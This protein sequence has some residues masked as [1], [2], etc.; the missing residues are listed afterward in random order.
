[1]AFVL[2]K[3][4]S[5]ASGQGIFCRGRRIIFS[6]AVHKSVTCAKNISEVTLHV[7]GSQ[8]Y[9]IRQMA[10]VIDLKP[11]VFDE[12]LFYLLDIKQQLPCGRGILVAQILKEPCAG[13]QQNYKK[14]C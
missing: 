7:V 12:A 4:F 2:F 13:Y 11:G 10:S 14:N 1:M 8:W 6:C 5:N 9:I 3:L